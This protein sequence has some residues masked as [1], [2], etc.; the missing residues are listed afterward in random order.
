MDLAL[1]LLKSGHLDLATLEAMNVSKY[2]VE[3]T[4]LIAIRCNC[5]SSERSVVHKV[6]AVFQDK[7][8][9]DYIHSPCSVC[10]CNDGMFFV[11]MKCAS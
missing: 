2:L 3:G 4:Q 10:S 5:L 1:L 11:H 7:M 8:N 9:G 6:Y